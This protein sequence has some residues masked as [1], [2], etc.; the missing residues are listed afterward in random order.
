VLIAGKRFDTCRALE[1]L[2]QQRVQRQ[3]SWDFCLRNNNVIK[4]NTVT[5]AAIGILK[6][7]GSSGNLIRN[8]LV[9]GAPVTVQDPSEAKL[10]RVISPLR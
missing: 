6:A 2:L 9:F 5:E 7:A 1:R 3:R 8:N 10:V 4:R